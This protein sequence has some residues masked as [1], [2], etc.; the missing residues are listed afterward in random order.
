MELRA[1]FVHGSQAGNI[2][3]GQ[4]IGV[5]AA[6]PDAFDALHPGGALHQVGQAG[7][8]VPA[9]TQQADGGQ[10]HL[11]VARVRQPPQLLQNAL[12]AAAAHRTPGAGNHTV[13]AL[14]SAAI[15]NFHKGPGVVGKAVHGQLLKGFP[16]LMGADVHHL[17]P[18]TVDHLHHI[19]QNGPAV[20]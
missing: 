15:L 8:G 2:P 13:G 16:F 1:Q 4:Q 6:Q 5:Q 10:N 11:A 19:L 17:A 18:L 20:A 7:A 14:P 12:F 9:V 3:V